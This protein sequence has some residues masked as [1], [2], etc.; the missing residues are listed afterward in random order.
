MTIPTREEA[1]KA[2]ESLHIAA[3]DGN[4]EHPGYVHDEATLRSY[5][6]SQTGEPV[7]WRHRYWYK[8]LTPEMGYDTCMVPWKL[9]EKPVDNKYQYRSYPGFVEEPLFASPVQPDHIADV[10]KMICPRSAN[11]RPESFTVRECVAAGECGCGES[12]MPGSTVRTTLSKG[13]TE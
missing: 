2:L 12:V 6:E 3:C 7:A 11:G 8:G 10:G 9:T 13:I 1:L 4:L 5:I